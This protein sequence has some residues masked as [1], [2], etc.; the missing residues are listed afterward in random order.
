MNIGDVKT[1]MAIYHYGYFLRRSKF[2]LGYYFNATGEEFHPLYPTVYFPWLKTKQKELLDM[3]RFY[4]SIIRKP[5]CF[6]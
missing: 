5:P 4:T 3:Q 1:L 6:L 2:G